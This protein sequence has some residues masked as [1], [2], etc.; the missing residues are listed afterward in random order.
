M[1][2]T[3]VLRWLKVHSN[4]IQGNPERLIERCERTVRRHAAEDAWL[5][6]K[7]Y[8]E[9][10][11]HEWEKEWGTHAGESFVARE[12]CH[13]LAYE[14][15]QHEPE[16]EVGAEEHLAGG[17]IQSALTDEGWGF[18]SGWVRD[19]AQREEHEVWSDIVRFTD[20]RGREIVRHF[21]FKDDSDYEHTRS[22]SVIASRVAGI[23]ARDY[24]LQAHPR[25]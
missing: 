5:S 4:E 1:N 17:R 14:L 7:S 23:L 16:V 18:V 12:I 2:R 9:S 15:K 13:Q 11:M 20:K 6:A 8:V 19:V 22:Y 21:D 10:R 24:S 3:E 25:P